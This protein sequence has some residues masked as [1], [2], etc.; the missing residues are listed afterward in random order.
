[1]EKL[2]VAV[3]FSTASCNAARYAADM[4]V[5]IKAEIILFHVIDISILISG[6]SVAADFYTGMEKDTEEELNL[7]KEE[8]ITRTRNKVPVSVNNIS[9]LVISELTGLC[10]EVRPLAVIMGAQGKSAVDRFFLGSNTGEAIQ[11]LSY[12]IFVIPSDAVYT[13]VRKILLACDMQNTRA[14]PFRK[15][16]KFVR[17]LNAQ[18]LVLNIKTSEK[19]IKSESVLVEDELSALAPAYYSI[20]NDS[21][22]SGINQF[23]TENQIDLLLLV[24]KSRNLLAAVFH[25]SISK[26]IC[27]HP[28]IPVITL[29]E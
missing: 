26:R 9:G 16:E 12:P 14:L 22:E 2:I 20:H 7:L 29:S 24:P 18:L 23:V 1:M 10:N 8:L 28:A 15:I 11:R 25:K 5:Q 21:V 19:N 17:L 27:W 3:D 13:S 4:A 6:V